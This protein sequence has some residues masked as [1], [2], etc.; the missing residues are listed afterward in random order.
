MFSEVDCSVL[1]D[2]LSFW[3]GDDESFNVSVMGLAWSQQGGLLFF[4]A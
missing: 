1:K 4:A 2:I 3:S